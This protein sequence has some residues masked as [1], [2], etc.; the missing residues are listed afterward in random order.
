MSY[1]LKNSEDCQIESHNEYIDLQYTLCG[2][3]GIS[4]F[5]SKEVCYNM[6]YD[7]QTDVQLS[8]QNGLIPIVTV[9][10]TVGRFCLIYPGEPHRPMEKN[11]IFQDT[12]KKAVIKIKVSEND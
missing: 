5:D 6:N 3:E 1:R 8:D 9:N 2:T 11:T 4:L 12:V 10:N 7:K